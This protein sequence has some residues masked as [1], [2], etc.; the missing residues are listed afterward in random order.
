MNNPLIHLTTEYESNFIHF[1]DRGSEAMSLAEKRAILKKLESYNKA[2]FK[3]IDPKIASYNQF[4]GIDQMTKFPIFEKDE[5]LKK[6]DFINNRNSSSQFQKNKHYEILRRRQQQQNG[7]LYAQLIETDKISHTKN[8]NL[9]N[10]LDYRVEK[11]I[12]KPFTRMTSPK[13]N[14]IDE[15]CSEDSPKPLNN[16]L[17]KAKTPKT[18]SLVSH[19]RMRGNKL[20]APEYADLQGKYEDRRAL[21]KTPEVRRSLLSDLERNTISGED[22]LKKN[23]VLILTSLSGIKTL[24]SRIKFQDYYSP[25]QK[26]VYKGFKGHKPKTKNFLKED[27]EAISSKGKLR[28][29]RINLGV[30]SPMTKE[31]MKMNEM[32]ERQCKTPEAEPPIIITKINS[33][34]KPRY[35]DPITDN[36]ERES[37]ELQRSHQRHQEQSSRWVKR[38]KSKNFSRNL[39][40]NSST[41][42][43]NSFYMMRD[44]EN[45]IMNAKMIH[46][47]SLSRIFS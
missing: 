2:D 1:K 17:I 15:K 12:N 20:K 44:T 32:V 11:I 35:I 40:R 42:S 31:R 39:S 14:N 46:K 7:N 37:H 9:R 18:S 3:S 36:K 8:E 43:L 23:D 5:T 27:R 30:C 47:D 33:S 25:S 22:P 13:F 29:Q 10:Y 6:L 45:I 16:E 24:K 38:E 21:V 26:V 41:T 28:H 34:H 19:N 4:Q